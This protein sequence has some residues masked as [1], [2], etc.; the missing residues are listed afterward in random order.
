MLMG[1]GKRTGR[2]QQWRGERGRLYIAGDCRIQ[3][4][5]EGRSR[6]QNWGEGV[7]E[8][9]EYVQCLFCVTGRE[10]GVVRTLEETE[11][12]RA[13]F[14]QKV[15]LIW[16]KDAW[17]QELFPLFPGYVFVYSHFLIPYTTLCADRNVLRIL[18]YDREGKESCL[19]DRDRAFAEMILRTNGV[20]G[21]LDAVQEGSYVRVNEGALH[22]FNGHVVKVDK[23]KRLAKVEMDILGDRRDV[24]LAFHLLES[25]N[26]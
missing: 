26:R 17:V 3:E 8:R 2:S 25:N 10:A 1:K 22:D 9:F 11:G 23:R 7:D 4:E 16:K 5:C 21:V 20:V 6:I 13:V 18:T 19:N 15:K 24:W 12:V 14:P